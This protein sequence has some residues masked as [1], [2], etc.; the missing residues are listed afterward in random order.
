MVRSDRDQA[1]VRWVPCPVSRVQR[2][3]SAVAPRN[4]FMR[5]PTLD[6]GLSTWDFD[7]TIPF[8]LTVFENEGE[9]LEIFLR[10]GGRF[11]DGRNPVRCFEGDVPASFP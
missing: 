7:L 1:C 5:F 3:Q 8:P 6:S 11:D 4:E 9:T 10:A 2:G